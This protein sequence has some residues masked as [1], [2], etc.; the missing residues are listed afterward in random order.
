MPQLLSLGRPLIVCI[1]LPEP[2]LC[3]V[4]IVSILWWTGSLPPDPLLSALIDDNQT[5]TIFAVVIRPAGSQLA[6]VCRLKE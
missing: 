6:D 1:P 5:V 4:C 3:T 2:A